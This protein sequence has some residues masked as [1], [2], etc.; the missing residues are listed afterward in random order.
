V[1]KGRGRARRVHVIALPTPVR[2]TD[3]KKNASYVRF[4]RQMGLLG[5]ELSC[6]RITLLIMD[7]VLRKQQPQ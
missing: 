2:K 7:S 1:R 3:K 4:D 6:P 5:H